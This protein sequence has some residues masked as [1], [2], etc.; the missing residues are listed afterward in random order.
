MSHNFQALVVPAVLLVAWALYY[1]EAGTDG[2]RNSITS[3]NNN[4]ISTSSHSISSS[5]RTI[6]NSGTKT[7]SG[8]LSNPIHPK[9][10]LQQGA[11]LTRARLPVLTST[12]ALNP[13][14]L[15][16]KESSP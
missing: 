3:R 8:N 9:A 13:K 4:E 5:S 15:L 10:L 14:A 16:Q 12:P 11:A 6:S 7:S 2:N 1:T